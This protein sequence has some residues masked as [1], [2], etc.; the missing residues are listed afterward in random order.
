MNVDFL[1][2][3]GNA[4]VRFPKISSR[5]RIALTKKENESMPCRTQVEFPRR[6]PK[7]AAPQLGRLLERM[8]HIGCR[9]FCQGGEGRGDRMKKTP[10]RSFFV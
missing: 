9:K 4:V 1:I 3:E 8:H 2:D 7:R 6:V 10:G 5:L